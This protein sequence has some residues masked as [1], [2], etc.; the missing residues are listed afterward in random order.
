MQLHFLDTFKNSRPYFVFSFVLIPLLVQYK[1]FDN[2]FRNE[3]TMAQLWLVTSL[4]L[5]VNL[6]IRIF[7][8]HLTMYSELDN[9]FTFPA[10]SLTPGQCSYLKI[11]WL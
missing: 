3:F 9:Q 2:S 7:T 11:K 6:L 5:L 8:V 10:R 4:D 1:C